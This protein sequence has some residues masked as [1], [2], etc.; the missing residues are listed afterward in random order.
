MKALIGHRVESFLRGGVSDSMESDKVAGSSKLSR[1]N[2]TREGLAPSS[3][4][5]DFDDIE[6]DNDDA[7]TVAS[8][9]SAS[10][11]T[12]IVLDQASSSASASAAQNS[13]L[14]LIA[15]NLQRVFIPNTDTSKRKLQVEI[16]SRTRSRAL[17]ELTE[18]EESDNSAY[19]RTSQT[20]HY[21]QAASGL[22]NRRRMVI[23]CRSLKMQISSFEDEWFKANNR[24]PKGSER[25]HMSDHYSRY[26]EM[27]KW[28]RDDAATDI[29]KMVRRFLVRLKYSRQRGQYR[30]LPP[31][32]NIPTELYAR[33]RLLLNEKREL[34]RTLKKFDD[35]FTATHGH[36]PRKAD[37]EIMRPMYQ[38]YHDVKSELDVIRA[39]IEQSHGYLP[40]ELREDA[41][42]DF[43]DNREKHAA[44]DEE[45]L[46]Q[47][48]TK[49]K[50]KSS[51]DS[52]DGTGIGI[53]SSLSNDETNAT[54]VNIR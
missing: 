20:V 5:E 47:N 19:S 50:R 38:S 7:M 10:G 3:T 34:K 11:S 18:D 46:T 12:A 27:K 33:Y 21:H 13:D 22:S 44:R 15:S 52:G 36:A 37:K 8:E 49:S 16:S 41:A 1:S 30:Q 45:T 9:V 14:E 4:S 54:A 53:W 39:T 40:D 43:R 31:P 23:E 6:T 42:Q 29:Q 51:L 35:D 17:S 26:K 48:T 32:E 2:K 28:I 25:G 24:L